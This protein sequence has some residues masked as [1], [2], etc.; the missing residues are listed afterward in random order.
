MA[1]VHE[2][3]RTLARTHLMPG[4]LHRMISQSWLVVESQAWCILAGRGA[5]GQAL[6]S[7]MI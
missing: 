5:L 7:I 2:R 4:L 1:F 6:G 3:H